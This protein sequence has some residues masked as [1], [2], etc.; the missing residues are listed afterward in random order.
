MEITLVNPILDSLDGY[1]SGD[2]EN[3]QED[4]IGL[5][6]DLMKT[7]TDLIVTS[8]N[9]LAFRPSSRI[10]ER[11]EIKSFVE[12]EI[13]PL[14]PSDISP[15]PVVLGFDLLTEDIKFNPYNGIDAIVVYLEVNN[16]K[17][18]YKTHIWECWEDSEFK[19]CDQAGF[20]KQNKF[21]FFSLCS[22]KI[23]L[24]SCGDIAKYCHNNMKNLEVCDIY[25]D[26]SH[27]SLIGRTSQ[28][29]YSPNIIKEGKANYI[30]GT[31]Q[32]GTYPRKNLKEQRNPYVFQNK[33]IITCKEEIEMMES[34][35]LE[36]MI[37]S[38]YIKP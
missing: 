15:K 23:G 27:A 34:N 11:C 22:K 13:L 17:L 4:R 33:S 12:N 10:S 29:R 19:L 26:L 16:G 14:F 31:Q 37:T 36:F 20:L 6:V 2:A 24:L 25:L 35:Q 18:T 30:L 7:N 1:Y 5:L 8:N 38:V 3:R 28:C 32:R 9:Y 21:R